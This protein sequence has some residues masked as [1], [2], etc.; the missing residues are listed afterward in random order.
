MHFFQLGQVAKKIVKSPINHILYLCIIISLPLFYWA[1]QTEGY[2]SITYIVIAVILIILFSV[3]YF[4]LLFKKP[5]YLRSE[6][7]Q[8]QMNKMRLFYGH[9]DKPENVKIGDTDSLIN[10]PKKN[11]LPRTQENESK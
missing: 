2:I 7:Y 3:A 4:Y 10:N 5:E 11:L 9:K 6:E 8:F 1:T